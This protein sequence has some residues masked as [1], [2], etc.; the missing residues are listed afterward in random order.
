MTAT[1]PTEEEIAKLISGAPFAST[2]SSTKARAILALFAPVMAAKNAETEQL[3][4]LAAVAMGER[5]KAR[6]ALAEER[7][8]CAT[9][10]E[11]FVPTDVHPQDMYS[12]ASTAGEIAAAIR[13][14]G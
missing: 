12:W 8:R 11:T 14:G 4:M 5:D 13:A 10:A 9:V 7:E 2:R 3:S 1:V 6:R